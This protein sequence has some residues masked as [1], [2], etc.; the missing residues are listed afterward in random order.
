MKIFCLC[1]DEVKLIYKEVQVYI[2]NRS[3]WHEG[4]TVFDVGADINDCN[5][6]VDLLLIKNGTTTIKTKIKLGKHPDKGEQLA[7][8]PR[9]NLVC[10]FRKSIEVCVK[11]IKQDDFELL[12]EM[13]TLIGNRL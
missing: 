3:E 12:I 4:E 7:L 1:K 6:M 5:V 2:K 11:N 8:Y 13:F 9:T 10:D